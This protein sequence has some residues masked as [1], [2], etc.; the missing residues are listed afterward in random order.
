MTKGV[1]A[2]C[3]KLA[4]AFYKSMK[5]FDANAS[6]VLEF[7]LQEKYGIRIGSAPC[8]SIEEIEKALRDIAGVAADILISRMRSFLR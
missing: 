6:R 3:S 5:V 8:S 4:D 2:D 1:D 7:H